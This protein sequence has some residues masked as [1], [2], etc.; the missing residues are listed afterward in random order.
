M[1]KENLIEEQV[2][3][4]DL[5]I[6]TVHGV[7][8]EVINQ[9]NN[10]ID[11][12]NVQDNSAKAKSGVWRKITSIAL[13]VL[14]VAIMVSVVLCSTIKKDFNYGFNS[15]TLITLH[16]SNS[17]NMNDGQTLTCG[18]DSYNKFMTLYNDSFKTTLFGVL[19][20]G[21]A[22]AGISAKEGYKSLSSLSNTYVEFFYNESQTLKVNGKEYDARIVSNTD[23]IS[24][25]IEVNNTESLSEVNAYFKYRDTGTNNYSYVRLV[26]FAAQSSLYDFIE[27]G[28]F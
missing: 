27:N 7:Q 3:N 25:I 17:N 20:Q 13:L 5:D 24:I 1:E 4:Q 28:E 23:Y 15:P 12:Q 9:D 2:N 19:F 21:K 16:T 22:G 10:E 18:T 6:Q 14:A 26:T 11:A 8:A